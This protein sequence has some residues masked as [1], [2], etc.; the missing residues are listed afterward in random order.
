M[1][2]IQF[3]KAIAKEISKKL[4]DKG[5]LVGAIGDN[6]IRLVPPLVITKEEVNLF[7]EN[8]EGICNI[9]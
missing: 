3:N 9:L 2:G 6:T 7:I 4:F 8:L 5:F 1:L